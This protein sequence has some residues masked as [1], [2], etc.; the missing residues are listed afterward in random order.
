MKAFFYTAFA[1]LFL[2]TLSSCHKEHNQ[3][4]HTHTGTTGALEFEMEHMF[5]ASAFQVNT[6]YVNA[7][8]DTVLFYSG[9]YTLSHIRFIK[10]DGSYFE[11]VLTHEINLAIPGSAMFNIADIPNGDYT[12]VQFAFGTDTSSVYAHIVGSI[13]NAAF[14]Y[15]GANANGPA[16]T[17]IFNFGSVL[18]IAPDAAPVLHMSMNMETLFANGIN[19]TSYSSIATGT[20]ESESFLNNVLLAVSFEHLHQ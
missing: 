11:S 17:S 5:G 8:G 7:N 18:T 15:S 3:D 9:S 1:M 19:P 12:G 14:D 10:T 13:A 20:A 6:P 4:N 2:F 16:Y